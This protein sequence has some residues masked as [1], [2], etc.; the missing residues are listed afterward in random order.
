MED[1]VFFNEIIGKYFPI[2]EFTQENGVSYFV[3]GNYS[4][5]SFSELVTE[6]DKIGYLPFINPHGEN[7]QIKLAQKP[8]TTKSRIHFNV[9]LFIATIGTT[10]FAGYLLGNSWVVAIGFAIAL[11]AIIGT[12]ETAHFL[13]ARKHGV[14]ATLP[15][16]IPAP[17]MI[18][19]FGAVINVKSPIPNR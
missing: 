1:Y 19:T 8:E 17:T 11:L 12:H 9:L 5:E 15:Y 14:E 13:A 10:L 4:S 6:L 16:F 3:V 7:Y 2:L 18:G